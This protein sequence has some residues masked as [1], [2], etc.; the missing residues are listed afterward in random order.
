M[1]KAVFIMDMP[2]ACVECPFYYKAEL[3]SMGNFIYKQL[4][5]CKVEA[6]DV[7]DVYLENIL[8]EKPKWCPLKLYKSNNL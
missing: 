2:S 8:K 1:D 3:L 4:Y 5:R 7:E 6:Q